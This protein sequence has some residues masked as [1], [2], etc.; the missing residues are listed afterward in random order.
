[1][2]IAVL[3]EA[4]NMNLLWSMESAHHFKVHNLPIP[5]DNALF[6]AGARANAQCPRNQEKKKNRYS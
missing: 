4:N 6:R 1:M 5:S 3:H 2:S